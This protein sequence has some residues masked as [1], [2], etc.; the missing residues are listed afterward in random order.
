MN[1]SSL[2]FFNDQFINK[3]K[4][5]TNEIQNPMFNNLHFI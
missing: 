5:K 4:N 1:K 3:K 2:E